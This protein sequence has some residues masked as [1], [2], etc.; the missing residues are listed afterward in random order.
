MQF[1]VTNH[2]LMDIYKT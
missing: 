1:G 2:I